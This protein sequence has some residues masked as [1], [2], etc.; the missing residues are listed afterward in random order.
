MAE[1]SDRRKP[2]QKNPPKDYGWSLYLIVISLLM[3]A[4]FFMSRD[5][6]YKPGDNVGYNIG[7]LGGLMMLSL[8]LYPL[9][10]R[11]GF[12]RN[13]GILPVW[14][15]WHM[16]FGILGPAMIMFHSTFYI[17]SIN[18]GV[19]LTCMMLVSGSGIF[20]RFFY[21]KIHN[22]LYGRQANLKQHQEDLDGSGDVKS[23]LSFAPEIQ[24]NLAE[25]RDFT[26][27][28]AKSGK[29]KGWRLLT[30]GFRV[31]FLSMGLVRDLEDVMYSNANE[32]QWNNAQMNRLDQL[33]YQNANFIR[34]YLKTLQDVA[35]FGTY[36]KLFSMWHVFHIPL[37]YM[38][39]FTAVWH[40]IAVHMY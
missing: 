40:V 20:G 14:F 39:A 17:G 25:F 9:R 24:N 12:M 6:L 5:N 35:Q 29:L 8:L 28:T 21:T 11:A 37:V 23:I 13:L 26:T 30:L 38:L 36:E 3:V 15:K 18:A 31:R 1:N 22:G 32:K 16:V 2:R 7:L 10:K 4:G 19:A 34:S 33:F 27:G